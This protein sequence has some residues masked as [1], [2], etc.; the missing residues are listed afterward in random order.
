[1]PV[2]AMVSAK[3]APGVTVCAAALAAAARS[4]EAPRDGAVL[5]EFDPAG[6]DL[7][8]LFGART[9]EPSLLR[10]AAD[11]RR[12]AGPDALADHVSEVVPGLPA[13]LAPSTAH[14]ATA[15]IDSVRGGALMS[16]LA[17][18]TGWVVVD[19]GRWD[20]SQPT[21]ARVGG[22][23]VI[24]VVCRSTAVSIAHALD[25]IG[26]LRTLAPTSSL[27]VVQLGSEPYPP[28]ETAQ[29]AA[30]VAADVP[31]LGPVAWDPKGVTAL[32]STGSASRRWSHSALA[33]SARRLLEGLTS[34]A[35]ARPS[36]ARHAAGAD[37]REEPV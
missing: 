12:D 26:P 1:M 29:A 13:L 18:V 28:A 6:G 36:W 33:G 19:A 16:G 4:R 14:A 2:L 34:L 25:L 17:A 24:A 37:R 23:D 22:A 21:S 11:V 15:V 35:D 8:V 9:G 7:E 31:V 27:A 20:R 10:V 3:G 32:W 5:V 30:Q